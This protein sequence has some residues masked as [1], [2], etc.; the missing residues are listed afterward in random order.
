MS[1]RTNL[2]IQDQYSKLWF[3][4]HSDGYPE[5]T[6]KTLCEFMQRVVD[7]TIRNNVGQ[8][9]GWLIVIGHEEYKAG[10][11]RNP[12]GT[13]RKRTKDE[14]ERVESHKKYSDW[15][16]G[17]Y[18]PTESRHADIEYLYILDLP[19]G[20]VQVYQ[21]PFDADWDKPEPMKANG[22]KEA[23]VFLG[24]LVFFPGKEPVVH[25]DSLKLAL[26]LDVA[27]STKLA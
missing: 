22:L 3:Y 5:G 24:S 25:G 15:K 4:R 19:S 21:T 7:N 26:G 2:I 27:P 12:D 11:P 10:T 13:F 23:D 9:A 20:I 16:V 18:E 17:S 1:T 6:Y 14:Q 8:A